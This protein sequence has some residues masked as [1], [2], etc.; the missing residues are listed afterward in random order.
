MRLEVTFKTNNAP[1][2]VR[3]DI[4]PYFRLFSQ[5]IIARVWG[6][7]FG[8]PRSSVHIWCEHPNW[9]RGRPCSARCTK[10]ACE[11]RDAC[12]WGARQNVWYIRT[13]LGIRRGSE[14]TLHKLIVR[15]FPLMYQQSMDS[16][17]LFAERS[18]HSRMLFALPQEYV[19]IERSHRFRMPRLRSDVNTALLLEFIEVYRSGTVCTHCLTSVYSPLCNV[20]FRGSFSL[21][22]LFC[23]LFPLFFLF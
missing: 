14:S 21:L 12:G 7:V 8:V 5:N 19:Y 9:V 2:I 11:R 20:F 16:I 22:E 17:R 13:L 4:L 1:N 10:S 3:P 18:S 6:R 15:E 23:N